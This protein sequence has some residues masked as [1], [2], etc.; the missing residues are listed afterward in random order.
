MKPII[1]ADDFG[2]CEKHDEI[3]VELVKNRK[4]NAISVLVHGE[5]DSKRVNEVR[6]MRD[7]LSIG[8]HLNLTMVL[9]KIQPLGS[10]ETLIIKSLLR[11]LDTHEI[12]KI[13]TSQIRSF[14]KI[15][16]GLPDFI[17]GHEHVH[18]LPSILEIL[19]EKV[20]EEPFSKE[21]W[22][23]SPATETMADLYRELSNA[24]FKVLII[25]ALGNRARNKLNKLGILTNKN[26]AG[27]FNLKSPSRNFKKK[28]LHLLTLNKSD[29]VIMVHP[30]AFE[31]PT[32]STSHSNELRAIEATILNESR[33]HLK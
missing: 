33:I 9:P 28:Y 17:D 8:L 31:S 26:F 16:G 23:R 29:T 1:V 14:E 24:G 4:I 20:V 32:E 18:I 6:K 27:F 7:F 2:L 3:I 11:V 12:K 30:G 5:L 19:T 15:F 13:I 10:I 25:S 22:I 21:F